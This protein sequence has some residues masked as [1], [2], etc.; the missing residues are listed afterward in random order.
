MLEWKFADE[1]LSALLIHSDFSEIDSSRMETMG[2]LDSTSSRSELA[3]G[4]GRELLSRGFV[5]GGFTSE[6]VLLAITSPEGLKSK[7][8]MELET[9]RGDGRGDRHLT[10]IHDYHVY[11]AIRN[12]DKSEGDKTKDLS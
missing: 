3:S 9:S 8:K 6:T 1:R 10:R 4:F 5:T 2:F 11:N 12:P 7:R